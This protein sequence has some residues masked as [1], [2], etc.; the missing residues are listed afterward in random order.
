MAETR[1]VTVRVSVVPGDTSGIDQATQRA[2]A[3]T[4]AAPAALRGAPAPAAGPPPLPAAAGGGL[5]ANLQAALAQGGGGAARQGFQGIGQLGQLAQSASAGVGGLASILSSLPGPLGI[6]GAAV[7][8]VTGV[9]SLMAEAFKRFRPS[10]QEILQDIAQSTQDIARQ[11]ETGRVTA[12]EIRRNLPAAVVQAVAQAQAQ[13]QGQQAA[14]LVAATERRAGVAVEQLRGRNLE[15]GQAQ[16][17]ALLTDA[18]Q[19]ARAGQL[20]GVEAAVALPLRIQEI[21]ERFRPGERL[22]EELDALRRIPDFAALSRQQIQQLAQTVTEPL[23]RAEAELR[24]AQAVRRAGQA[25]SLRPGAPEAPDTGFRSTQ[26]DIL[27]L[28]AILQQEMIRSD[29][30]E[31]RFQAQMRLWQEFVDEMRRIGNQIRPAVQ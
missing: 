3:A 13:G 18:Q 10:L 21:F 27:S 17:A 7:G 15:Q 25:P 30:E 16:I 5:L 29:R 6:A 8:A 31:A 14:Q 4:Q 1:D 9:V 19:R 28:P 26:G 22:P 23:V 12:E 24:T 20:E 2:Q 11:R